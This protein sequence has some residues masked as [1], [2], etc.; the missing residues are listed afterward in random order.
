MEAA[1]F[2]AVKIANSCGWLD[3]IDGRLVQKYLADRG[4]NTVA[5]R[6]DARAVP[7]AG[8]IPSEHVAILNQSVA[9]WNE[10][11]I[12]NP[13]IWPDLKGANLVGADLL[14]ANFRGAS[15]HWANLRGA[16]LR[17][18]NLFGANLRGAIL[19]EANLFGADLSKTMLRRQDFRGAILSEAN[20]SGV[21]LSRANSSR[22]IFK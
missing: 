2:D 6:Q 1:M 21:D 16:N 10:W 13:G 9:A 17:R 4:M 19:S 5:G 15:F 11:R 14:G 18:A 20:L 3:R 8:Q 12:Q 7:D 22:A